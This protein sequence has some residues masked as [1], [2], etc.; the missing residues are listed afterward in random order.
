MLQAHTCS[1]ATATSLRRWSQIVLS[2]DA[3]IAKCTAHCHSTQALALTTYLEQHHE[4]E[5]AAVL[6]RNGVQCLP[7]TVPQ[8][9]FFVKVKTDSRDNCDC[10]LDEMVGR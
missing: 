5:T 9:K 10:K 6:H 7:Q 2:I 8:L 1:L 4:R 3:T